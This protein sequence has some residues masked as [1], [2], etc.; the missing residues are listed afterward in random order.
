MFNTFFASKILRKTINKKCDATFYENK[1]M[2][3]KNNKEPKVIPQ[4]T[5]VSFILLYIY[6]L[7]L[8]PSHLLVSGRLFYILRTNYS[9][10]H[11][12]VNKGQ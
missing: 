2:N 7:F 1:G 8:F 11:P 4:H 12:I 6:F 5:W 9:S 10:G 3:P